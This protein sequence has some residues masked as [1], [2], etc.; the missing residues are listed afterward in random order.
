VIAPTAA[1]AVWES[2][3]EK[4]APGIWDVHVLY[5]M[6]MKQRASEL[7]GV[8]EPCF[9]ITN[10]TCWM[11]PFGGE[12]LDQDWDAVVIDESHRI[13]APGSKRALFAAKLRKNAKHKVC[14][15]G[16]PMP[17]SPLDIYGQYRFLDP[18]IFGTR[19]AAFR[20]KYAVMG[21]YENKQ[22][23]GYKNQ[24]E[25]RERMDTLRIHFGKDVLDLPPIQ[26]LDRSCELEPKA[27]KKY[28][29]FADQMI[30]D[31]EDGVVTASNA[32]V[33]VLRL[34]QIAC[35]YAPKN[36]DPEDI[37]EISTAKKDLLADMI[38]DLD[39]P[40]VVFCRFTPDLVRV[41]EIAE[42]AGRDYMEISGKRNDYKAWTDSDHEN[43]IMGVQIQAGSEGIDLTD[44]RVGIFYSYL[45]LGN[46]Q[47]AYS[48]I[49]RPGQKDNT[50]IYRLY[51]KGTI[52]R[53]TLRQLDKKKD[54]IDAILHAPREVLGLQSDE[55]VV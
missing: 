27:Q 28:R 47:Q 44:A 23:F 4:H 50:V 22:I 12:I 7:R 33:R 32:L 5:D 53:R 35:G 16:T 48:R 6:S 45:S 14:L 2:E 39:E 42:D 26:F 17:H 31:I 11:E 29:E 51:A 20:D 3:I 40:V 54:I 34:Q 55:D 19:F 24:K 36:D 8:K 37:V 18:A 38:E 1:V 30:T 52:E 15:T 21:G 46:Y 43:T 9:I 49:H 41:K 25:M 13:K 10:D